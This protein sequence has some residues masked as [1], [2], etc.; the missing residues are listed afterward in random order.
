MLELKNRVRGVILAPPV[1]A[2]SLLAAAFAGCSST[3]DTSVGR[4]DDGG[5]LD[6]A[7]SALT[8]HP[9][10]TAILFP[11]PATAAEDTLLRAEAGGARGVLLPDRGGPRR[12]RDRRERARRSGR[13][14]ATMNQNSSA[15]GP[16]A[17]A[18]HC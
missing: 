10:D 11:L 18:L 4:T 6:A 17:D 8:I 9:L 16:R 7:T 12:I 2:L 13:D 15:H 14:E 1:V 3:T 5:A